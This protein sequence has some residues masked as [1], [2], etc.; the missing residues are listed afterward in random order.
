MCLQTVS[1]KLPLSHLSKGFIIGE[2][3][4]ESGE[5]EL[6][7]L[8]GVNGHVLAS[9]AQLVPE[10]FYRLCD[11]AP[12]VPPHLYDDAILVDA[13][14]GV[15]QVFQLRPALAVNKGSGQYLALCLDRR[16]GRVGAHGNGLADTRR[17]KNGEERSHK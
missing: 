4:D 8:A 2:P 10:L 1:I 9:P 11:I 16:C 14:H 3:T 5:K 6:S 12:A 15:V 7:L 17:L 13:D